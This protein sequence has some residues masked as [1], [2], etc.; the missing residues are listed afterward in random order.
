VVVLLQCVIEGVMA[1][2]EDGKGRAV[3]ISEGGIGRIADRF[4]EIEV[5]PENWI[6]REERFS[7]FQEG[8]VVGGL[9]GP[10][11]LVSNRPVAIGLGLLI[12]GQLRLDFLWPG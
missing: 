4:R 1:V 2:F 8:L 3:I 7:L 11:C 12:P 5:V 6:D 9:T 10:S